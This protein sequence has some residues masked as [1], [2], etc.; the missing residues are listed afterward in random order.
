[1]TDADYALCTT[2]DPRERSLS[3]LLFA[4]EVGMARRHDDSG[5]RGPLLHPFK[6]HNLVWP[7]IE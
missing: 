2:S 5:D 6:N 7:G 1:M 4:E 3:E